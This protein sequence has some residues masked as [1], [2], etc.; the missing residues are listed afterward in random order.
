[1]RR[2]WGRSMRIGATFGL[3]LARA[4]TAACIGCVAQTHSAPAPGEPPPDPDGG[5]S[6]RAAAAGSVN[7]PSGLRYQDLRVGD[8]PA[9][10]PG[11]RVVLHFTGW[12]GTGEKFDSSLDRGEGFRFVLG[13]GEV[14]PGWEEGV[15]G[16]KPG[17]KR[18]LIIPAELAYG[19]RGSADGRVPAN[20]QLIVEVEVLMVQRRK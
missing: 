18:R 15:R 3:V 20:S 7:L 13:A 16:M 9:A 12:L 5:R 11:T 8:G 6:D 14:V 2:G 1:M 4:A 10:E 17:G 19:S